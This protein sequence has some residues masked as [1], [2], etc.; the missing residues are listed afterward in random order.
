MLVGQEA[1]HEAER[2]QQHRHQQQQR[3]ELVARVGAHRER[4]LVLRQA[5]HRERPADHGRRAG[6]RAQQHDRAAQPQRDH[7]EPAGDAD[8]PGEQRAARVG[9]HQADLEQGDPRPGERVERR[10]AGAPRAQ[11]QQR[12]EAQRRHQPGR[13]PIAERRAQAGVGLVRGQP[14]GE[15]LRQQRPA[16]DDQ[17]R[18]REPVQH[19]GPLPGR[20]PRE[21]HRAGEGEQVGQRPARL[22]PRVRRRERPQG[23]E[24]RVRGQQRE[25]Q[26]HGPAVQRAGARLRQHQRGGHQERPERHQPDLDV[27]RALQAEAAVGDERAR[28]EDERDGAGDALRSAARPGARPPARPAPARRPPG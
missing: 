24:R 11:P 9:Q 25:G 19:R 21:R 5:R 6:G 10:V 27:G 2:E 16:A 4:E 18:E 7:G 13:V 20:E 8:D 12:Q 14:A 3:A 15:D 1:R 17:A 23:R 28:G 26:H 22:D